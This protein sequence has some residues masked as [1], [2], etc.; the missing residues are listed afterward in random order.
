MSSFTLYLFGREILSLSLL[1]NPDTTT[2]QPTQESMDWVSSHS[3]QF[4]IGFTAP[5]DQV[6]VVEAR[7]SRTSATA[8][9]RTAST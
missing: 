6:P 1:P 3:G 9:S 4:E 8:S 2:T 7:R 5:Y